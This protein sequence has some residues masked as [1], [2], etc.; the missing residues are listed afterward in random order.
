MRRERVDEERESGRRERDWMR[1]ER[2][3]EER[4]SG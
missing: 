4:E 3:D 1:R 2:V